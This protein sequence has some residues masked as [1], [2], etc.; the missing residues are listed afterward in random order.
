MPVRVMIVDD[1]ESFR[2]WAAKVLRAGGMD[3]VGEAA[4]AALAM[5]VAEAVRPDVVLL[6]VRLPDGDGFAVCRALADTGL[7][8]VLCSM[9]GAHDYGDLLA[10]NRAAGCLSKERLS[11]DALR[12]LLDGRP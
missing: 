9:L 11:A 7:T 4:T 12:L 6:D 8:V 1:H 2:V 5:V 3:V 10:K